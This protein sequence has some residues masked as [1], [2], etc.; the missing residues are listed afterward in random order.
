[1]AAPEGVGTA[2]FPPPA[3]GAGA[4]VPGCA[5]PEGVGGVP[6][7]VGAEPWTAGVP[8]VPPEGGPLAAG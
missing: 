6:P 7:E 3:A 4:L 2:G 8:V 5:A 1:M